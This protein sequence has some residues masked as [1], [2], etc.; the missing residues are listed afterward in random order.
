MISHTTSFCYELCCF[1]IEDSHA[2]IV[3]DPD[4]L[5]RFPWHLKIM[6]HVR[7]VK[8]FLDLEAI[9]RHIDL[10]SWVWNSLSPWFIQQAFLLCLIDRGD[11]S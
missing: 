11:F 6:V 10:K 4:R 3:V 8:L 9:A 7:L 2:I 5:G 1:N